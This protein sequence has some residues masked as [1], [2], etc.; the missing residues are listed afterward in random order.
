VL[1][2]DYRGCKLVRTF[3]WCGVIGGFCLVFRWLSVAKD[4]AFTAVSLQTV[5]SAVCVL[6]ITPTERC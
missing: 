5:V 3:F 4:N 6:S 1:M 2:G